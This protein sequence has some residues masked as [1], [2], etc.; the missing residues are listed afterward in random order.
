MTGYA[1]GVVAGRRV[2]RLR[3][4]PFPVSFLS[5]FRRRFFGNLFTIIVQFF[6]YTFITDLHNRRRRFP[7]LETGGWEIFTVTTKMPGVASGYSAKLHNK[8]LAINH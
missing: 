6:L 1:G 7:R 3:F 2:F 5:V 8:K 4:Y